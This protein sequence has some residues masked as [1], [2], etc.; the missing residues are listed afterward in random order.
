MRVLVTG[1]AGF[2]GSAVT[3][4]LLDEGHTVTVLDDLSTGRR[5]NLDGLLSRAE[6][7]LALVEGSILD[8]C[9]TESVC[10]GA[11]HV[12]HLAAQVSVADSVARPLATQEINVTGT[13][14][15]LEAARSAGAPV[16]I[17]SSAA[18]YGNQS[19]PQREDRRPCCCSPYAASKLAAEQLALTWQECYGLPTLSLRFF[20]VFGP[21]QL[22]GDAYAA[23]VPAFVDRALAGA[24]L[25]VHG[26]GRQTRDFVPVHAV[27]RVIVDAVRRRMGC[28]T[29]VNVALGS[30][31]SLLDLIDLL[32]DR[33]G[34]RLEI[35]FQPA[36]PGD[37]RDS[38]GDGTLLRSLFPHLDIPDLATALDETVTWFE[39]RRATNLA[40]GPVAYAAAGR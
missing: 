13:A 24:P 15:V 27:A 11:G 39:S 10:A 38:L 19:G 37:I 31:V 28:P 1:G 30:S 29:P 14:N 17:A 26:D 5:T 3:A 8:R 12:V 22:P 18:V 21:R 7:R 32:S 6:G 20:N 2:I 34:R 25:T 9:L 36:R 33:L 40:D 4:A 16:V 35:E 23:V